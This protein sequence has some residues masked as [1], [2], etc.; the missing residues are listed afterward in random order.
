[1]ENQTLEEKFEELYLKSALSEW[2]KAINELKNFD[3][4]EVK[5]ELKK[6]HKLLK[7]YIVFKLNELYGEFDNEKYDKL[8]QKMQEIENDCNLRSKYNSL[9]NKNNIK[10]PFNGIDNFISWYKKQEKKCYYCEI[11]QSDLNNLF[12]DSKPINSK[13]RAF[14]GKLQIERLDPDKG[15]NEENCVLACCICNNAKSDMISTSDFKDYFSES[16]K[17]FYSALLEKTPNNSHN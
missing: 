6:K 2:D 16:I 11:A 15:Y 1:M 10:E 3:E 7:D 13:K 14:N 4:K 12:G 9:K 17:K 5:S 8:Y